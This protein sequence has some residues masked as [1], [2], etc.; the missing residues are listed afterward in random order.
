MMTKQKRLTDQSELR[1]FFLIALF[2]EHCLIVPCQDKSQQRSLG[3]VI[4]EII[5]GLKF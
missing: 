1:N 3:T 2:P 5:V 4:K